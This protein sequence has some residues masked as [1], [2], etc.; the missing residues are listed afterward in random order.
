MN[1]STS[2]PVIYLYVTDRA[3]ALAFYTETLGFSLYNA[4]PHGDSID[5]G[6]GFLR[7][8]VMPDHTPGPHPVVGWE[9]PD[10]T[11]V[12]EA[13]KGKGVTMTIYDGMGQDALGVWT[14]P[15]G[16]T[17]LAWFPDSEGNLLM[18]S[19]H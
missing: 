18:L 2:K 13:L 8:T 15:D 4:G 7:T 3:R 11:A 10:V 14:S 19:Q 1:L 16:T 5:M 9:V 6:H 17:K 12:A